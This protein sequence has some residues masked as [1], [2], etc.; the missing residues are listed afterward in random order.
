VWLPLLRPR[1]E[2]LLTFAVPPAVYAAY[3][4]GFLVVFVLVLIGLRGL[5]VVTYDRLDWQRLPGFGLAF[6][7]GGLSVLGNLGDYWLGQRTVAQVLSSMLFVLGTIIGTVAL[8]SGVMLIGVADVTTRV[9]PPW[10]RWALLLAPLLG[11][12][13]SIRPLGHLPSGYVL[14]LSVAWISVGTTVWSRSN[15]R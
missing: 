1:L 6:V 11:V 5:Y 14:P 10:S 8:L 12:L 2:P 7:G 13:L 15:L 3:G 4:R 9:L